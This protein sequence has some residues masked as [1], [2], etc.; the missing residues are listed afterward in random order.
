MGSSF[1]PIPMVREEP[2]RSWLMW[3]GIP[4]AGNKLSVEPFPPEIT[5]NG[6]PVCFSMASFQVF[7]RRRFS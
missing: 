4:G 3:G 2:R 6:C 5:L 1:N 7:R